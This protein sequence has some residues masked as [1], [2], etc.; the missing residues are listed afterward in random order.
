MQKDSEDVLK[1][2]LYGCCANLF[3]YFNF[4]L[5][6]FFFLC[7]RP[8]FGRCD[9]V[10]LRL[11]LHKLYSFHKCRRNSCKI[12]QKQAMSYQ[13]I[14]NCVLRTDKEL[15]AKHKKSCTSSSRSCPKPF[16]GSFERSSETKA[17]VNLPVLCFWPNTAVKLAKTKTT[18]EK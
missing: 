18:N 10:S 9:A 2:R 12:C 17:K 5:F 4:I 6:D 8:F 15:Q 3:F 11:A 13:K 1:T 7:L 16:L 14:F